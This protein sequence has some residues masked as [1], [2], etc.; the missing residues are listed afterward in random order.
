MTIH[1]AFLFGICVG[2]VM[3]FP[4]AI[5]LHFIARLLTYKSDNHNY[6][7]EYP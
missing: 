3:V 6:Y 5:V 1:D 2:F 7:D 4:V